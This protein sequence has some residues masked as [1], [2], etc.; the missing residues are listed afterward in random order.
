[1]SR[2]IFLIVLLTIFAGIEVFSFLGLKSA[3][4]PGWGLRVAKGLHLFG[5]LVTVVTFIGFFLTIRNGL[6]TMGATRNWLMGLM[7][8]FMVTKLT[9][10]AILLLGDVTRLVEYLFGKSSALVRG[11]DAA[12]VMPSRRRFIG[13]AG[14]LVA[15]IPFS[16]F[17]YGVIKGRYDYTVHRVKL[18]FDD[19]PEAFHG[20]KLVQISD[21]HAGSWDDKE[22]VARG[23]AMIQAENPDLLVFTGDL[24]NNLSAEIVPYKDLFT[25]LHAPLGKFAVLGNHDY[26]DYVQWDSLAAKHANTEEVKQH[27]ADMGFQMLNNGNVVIESGGQQIRLA[28]VENWGKPPFPQHGDLN[29]ALSQVAPEEFTILLS[30]DPTHWDMQVRDHPK[31]VHLTLSGHTHGF[32]MG[33]EIPGIKWSPVQWRYKRWAGIYEEGG[34]HLYVNRGFGYIGFPGRVGIWPEITVIELSRA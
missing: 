20:M 19:L 1:M 28:G 30:H 13:Q 7:V 18:A 34:Q 6:S 17:L 31:H 33:I 24:V 29:A 25:S 27:N 16:A 32:Q 26:G 3:I 23:V 11:D 22:A 8:T 15:A 10:S 5:A 12:V 4:R 21:I 9:F 14:L 2:T